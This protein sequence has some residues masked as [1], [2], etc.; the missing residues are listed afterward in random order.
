MPIEAKRRLVDAVQ[1]KSELEEA[2]Y[3][4]NLEILRKSGNLPSGN[5]SPM[6]L[7]RMLSQTTTYIQ[8]FCFSHN[9]DVMLSKDSAALL[10]CTNRN[11]VLVSNIID[12][13][14]TWP[15]PAAAIAYRVQEAFYNL[16]RV[17]VA[18]ATEL[19]YGSGRAN[20]NSGH[21]GTRDAV[22]GLGSSV[23]RAHYELCNLPNRASLRLG[24][25]IAKNPGST[26]A[27][28]GG[29]SQQKE[30]CQIGE[31]AANSLHGNMT[32][33]NAISIDLTADP[34]SSSV[35]T[36]D[37]QLSFA[38]DPR[39]GHIYNGKWRNSQ[40][41]MV[42]AALLHNQELWDEARA[43][44]HAYG[45]PIVHRAIGYGWAYA[46]ADEDEEYGI[47][48]VEHIEGETI[49]TANKM[50]TRSTLLKLLDAENTACLDALGKIH[51]RGVVHKDIYGANLLFRRRGPGKPLQSV[52][53]DFGFAELDSGSAGSNSRHFAKCKGTDYFQLLN[54]FKGKGV[55]L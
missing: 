44:I 21:G 11:A 12:Y 22:S 48:V 8:K 45:S 14:L 37:A 41:V 24:L 18:N 17:I 31:A 40:D 13:I 4:A 32:A 42:K 3:L 34:L 16:S 36:A 53:I 23:Q 50:D 39:C 55:H 47:L 19:S 25:G 26:P 43:E 7:Y 10:H 27:I 29:G 9:P 52:F 28:A 35:E 38:K 5:Q 33:I 6:Y 1:Q 46:A 2:K 54:A 51:K 49:F 30:A 15:H 20:S